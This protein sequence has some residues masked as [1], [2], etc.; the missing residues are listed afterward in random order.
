[1]KVVWDMA[2]RYFD[3]KIILWDTQI[4]VTDIRVFL[5]QKALRCILTNPQRSNNVKKQTFVFSQ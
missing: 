3:Q 2:Q 1:M 5:S 4:E